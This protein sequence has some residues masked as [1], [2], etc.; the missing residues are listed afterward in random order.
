MKKIAFT[1]IMSALFLPAL[2]QQDSSSTDTVKHQNKKKVILSGGEEGVHLGVHNRDTVKKH[3][4]FSFNITFSRFDLGF[5]RPI[6]NGSFT[7]QPQNKFLD[8]RGWK[9]INVGFDVAQMGFRFSPAFKIYLSA[10]FDWTHMRLR[11]DVTIQQN[12]TPLDFVQDTVSFSKNR[13][14]A[15]YLRVPLTFYIRSKDDSHGKRAHFAF[16]PE[17]GFLLNG[18]VKQISDERGKQKFNDNYNWTKF[19]YGAFARLGYGSAGL[20]AKYYLNDMFENSPAQSGMHAFA[21]GLT[22][23]F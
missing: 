14:S 12:V 13:F 2:A 6:D 18:R 1:L 15:S 23:G 16:G 4:N 3:S 17:L 21:F 19:R 8:Y 10:G 20:Y 5:M 22:F 9:T 7:L 11:E